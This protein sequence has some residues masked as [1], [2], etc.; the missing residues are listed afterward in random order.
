M[1]LSEFFLA[2]QIITVVAQIA[3]LL[4]AL[5]NGIKPMQF[6]YG[7]SFWGMFPAMC[8]WLLSR[9]FAEIGE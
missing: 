6:A 4:L 1:K 3:C 7:F 2:L 9:H 5:G 8:F